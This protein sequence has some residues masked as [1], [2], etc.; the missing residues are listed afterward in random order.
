MENRLLNTPLE[1][2]PILLTVRCD[3]LLSLIVFTSTSCEVRK[4][5][6]SR[7]LGVFVIVTL[8]E[9]VIVLS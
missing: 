5:L 1:V 8:L 9:A 4:L 3:I 6:D 2:G 7:L